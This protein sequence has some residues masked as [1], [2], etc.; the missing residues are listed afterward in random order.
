MTGLEIDYTTVFQAS[1]GPTALLTPQL[2]Y[3]DA[4]KEFLQLAGRTREQVIGHYLP[5]DLAERVEQ[6]AVVVRNIEASLRRV[7]ES[8]LR[9]VMDL[10]RYFMEQSGE[11]GKGEER[12]LTATNI[13]LFDPEGRLV[14]VLHRVQDVTDL[15][16]A[17][18][19]ALSLQ[20]AMLP[21]PRPLG[22]HSAAVRYRPAVDTLHVCGDWY[23]LV[24]LPDGRVAIAVGD[25][26]GHGL[27]AA[28]VMGE[29]RSALSAASRVTSGPARAL[30]ILG[31]YARSVDGAEN[32]TVTSAFIDWETLTVTYS[33][34]GHP[35]PALRGPDGA[36][37]FLD[38][39]TDPP[40][41][42]YPEHS[43]RF[44]ATV[45]FAAGAVLVLYTDGLIERRREDIDTGLGRLARSLTR[46]DATDPDALAD[47]LLVDL[48]PPDGQTDDTA[49]VVVPL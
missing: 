22:R 42:A 7:I 18:E 45:P 25:V 5:D 37:E 30:E 1:P 47:T 8:G 6:D 15:I 29:L 19:V 17:R 27:S 16:S 20:E 26:V 40:L 49:L 12:Y 35:P 14:L 11:R 2:V 13:P 32:T 36:V 21:A 43:S 24:D 46:C 33:R 4:N 48:L 28:G 9:D 39:V 23:D 44:E 3:A 34:A 41:A 10:Q 31:M 38:Q